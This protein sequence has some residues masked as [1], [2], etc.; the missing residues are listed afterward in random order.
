MGTR[1]KPRAQRVMPVHTN[2]NSDTGLDYSA[3]LVKDPNARSGSLCL[4]EPAGRV[5]SSKSVLIRSG[6]PVDLWVTVRR[7]EDHHIL[8]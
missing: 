3:G 2:Y 5:Y 8:E 1:Y 6:Q 4:A 7:V